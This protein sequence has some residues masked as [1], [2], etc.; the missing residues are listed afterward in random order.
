MTT[1]F[2]KLVAGGPPQ[3]Y[4]PEYQMADRQMVRL[5]PAAFRSLPFGVREE[6]TRRRCTIPQ[7]WAN[8]KPHNVI[9]GAFVRKGQ[10]DWAVLCSVNRS[11]SILVFPNASVTGVMELAKERDIKQFQTVG[12]EQLGYSRAISTARPNWILAHW[13]SIDPEQRPPALDHDGINDVFVEKASTVL[14]LSGRRWLR[15]PG[16]D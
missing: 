8:S 7:V 4:P 10:T 9:K 6:L 12:G 2:A 11:S 15:L 13:I 1:A 3:P 14:F 16:A 5:P